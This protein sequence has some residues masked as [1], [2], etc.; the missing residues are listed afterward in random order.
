MILV[1]E[2][3]F[4]IDFLPESEGAYIVGGSV[5]DLLLKRS[6]TD[7]DIVVSGDA[8][9]YAHLLGARI[10]G[11]AVRIGKPG[12]DTVRVVADIG[13]FD[14]SAVQGASI[15]EDLGER[16]FTIN[17][18]ALEISSGEI[19]DIFGG[20]GDLAEKRIR[21]VSRRIFQQDPVRLI[22]AFRM[23]AD[24][25]FVIEP[26]TEAMIGK[27]AV[28]IKDTAGERVR[29]EFFKVLRSPNSYAYL[30]R[31]V[32]AGLLLEIFPEMKV[33]KGFGQNKHHSYDV[34]EHTMKAYCRL[35]G[36]VNRSE[37]CPAGTSELIRNTI[38]GKRSALLKCA[39]LLHDVGKPSAR[40]TD[41]TG[42]V[43]FFGHN[44]RSAE[45][46]ERIAVR[47]RF[48]NR[49]ASYLEAVIR[50]HNRPLHLYLAQEKGTLTSKGM[51]RFFIKCGELTPDV[52]LHSIADERGKGSA[53]D[54]GAFDRFVT[55]LSANYPGDYLPRA[56]GPALLTG[57]DLMAAFELSPSPLFGDILAAVEEGRLSGE[58]RS[59]EDALALAANIIDRGN[60][61][62]VSGVPSQF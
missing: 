38:K 61:S 5:R 30:T 42:A 58:I 13:I 8:Y 62:T 46:A 25:G 48:S 57:Y 53:V 22:R 55:T 18:V 27:E 47:L 7:Y 10:G 49:E 29:E 51:T 34:F 20:A 39:M 2:F 11:H 12:M 6:P 21:M 32:D 19:I 37:P 4:D 26:E 23:G 24:L 14:I 60:D 16:D 54:D 28:N 50:A 52:L 33:L 17:A 43:H 40:T 3:P 15:E 36:L 44:A 1:I 59:K 56:R 31:M 41:E 45:I 9:A 35:E